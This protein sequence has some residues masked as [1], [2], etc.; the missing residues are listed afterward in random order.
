MATRLTAKDRII[1]TWDFISVSLA[2]TAGLCLFQ[3]KYSDES[4]PQ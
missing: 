2:S 3:K 4:K 1:L